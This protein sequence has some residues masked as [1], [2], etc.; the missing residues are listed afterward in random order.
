MP[1]F[2]NQDDEVAAY[3]DLMHAEPLAALRRRYDP[4]GM[5]TPR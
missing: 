5:F 3:S 1:N 2:S 4:A